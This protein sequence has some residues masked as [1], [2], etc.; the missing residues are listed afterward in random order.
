MPL[1]DRP[2]RQ[3][4]VAANRVRIG[5]VQRRLGRLWRALR[6]GLGRR[7]PTS[8]GGRRGKANPVD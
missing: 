7:R 3:R 1:P 5:V 6:R 8:G 4:P 2:L